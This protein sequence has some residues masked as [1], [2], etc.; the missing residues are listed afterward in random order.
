MK[1]VS[2]RCA[3]FGSTGTLL[4]LLASIVGCGSGG[5]KLATVPVSGMVLLDGQ[6]IE[7]AHVAFMPNDIEKGRPANGTT[8]SSGNFQLKTLS[9]GANLSDGALPGEYKVSVVKIPPAAGSM[10]NMG[11]AGSNSAPDAVLGAPDS[12]KTDTATSSIPE[13][14]SKP[15]NSGLTATVKPSGNEP[16]KFELHGEAKG[17]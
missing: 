13:M 10:P 15:E 5:V 16:F 11:Q 8:D 4:L 3:L 1:A 6:P 2:F 12:A 17:I 14:Y 9:G 7:G